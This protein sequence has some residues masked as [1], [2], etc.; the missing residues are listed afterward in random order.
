M[1]VHALDNLAGSFP[2]VRVDY[3]AYSADSAYFAWFACLANRHYCA[4]NCAACLSVHWVL[5]TS[6]MHSVLAVIKGLSYA[7]SGY[8]QESVMAGVA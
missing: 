5:L 6:V 8:E 1:V 2:L 7:D 3:I 4:A